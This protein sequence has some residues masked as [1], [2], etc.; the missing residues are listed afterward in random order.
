MLP[1]VNREAAKDHSPGFQP[2]SAK[3]VR[4]PRP[5]KLRLAPLLPYLSA[6]RLALPVALA[7]QSTNRD[8][9]LL[10]ALVY[11]SVRK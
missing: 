2:V 6:T 9:R 10:E 3:T 8:F 4:E 5:T 7:L 1:D 11:A